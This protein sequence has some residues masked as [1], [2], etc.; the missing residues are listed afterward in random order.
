MERNENCCRIE[1]RIQSPY[2]CKQRF[3]L[4]GMLQFGTTCSFHPSKCVL[5]H[6]SSLTIVFLIPILFSLFFIFWQKIERKPRKFNPLV[7][8]KSLQ[9]NLP[10]DSKPKHTPKH[11]RPLLDERRQKGVIIDP[12]EK[13]I[14]ALVQHLQLM[15]GEKVRQKI[16]CFTCLQVL[17]MEMS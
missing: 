5:R 10:F 11:R 16:S 14:H 3:S 12:R 15:K 7:I 4:P 2:S 6:F 13:K 9:A 17:V 1:K 8:P